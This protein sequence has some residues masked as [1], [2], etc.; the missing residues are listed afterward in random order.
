MR[1]S[2]ESCPRRL[3]SRASL[4]T[5]ILG[6]IPGMGLACGN[7]GTRGTGGAA[8]S[9]EQLLLS[10]IGNH[11]WEDIVFGG[12]TKASC[13]IVRD[14]GEAGATSEIS[15]RSLTC[16]HWNAQE[17]EVVGDE[18]H[19]VSM[20]ECLRYLPKL[21]LLRT[22]WTDNPFPTSLFPVL[23]MSDTCRRVCAHLSLQEL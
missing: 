14:S 10:I 18:K 11:C 19:F 1:S 5:L 4:P 6:W 17:R 9:K 23:S 8:Q 20:A 22:T 15:C 2:L 7:D 16:R 21:T 12:V 3:S 13:M